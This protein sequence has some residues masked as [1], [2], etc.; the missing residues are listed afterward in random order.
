MITGC[1]PV[2]GTYDVNRYFGST[3]CSGDFVQETVHLSPCAPIP[4]VFDMFSN[5]LCFPAK[6]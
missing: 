2:A 6:R 3:D 5:Q 1:D 4:N